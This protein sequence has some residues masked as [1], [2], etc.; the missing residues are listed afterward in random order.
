LPPTERSIRSQIAAH[1]SWANT[2]D[3]TARTAKARKALEDKFL[4][5]ADGDPSARSICG[6]PTTP[7]WHSSPLRRAVAVPDLT[8]RQPDESTEKAGPRQ[9]A[10]PS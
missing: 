3:R 8:R 5:E 9:E 7:G 6:A 10:G 2:T 4:A 1:T